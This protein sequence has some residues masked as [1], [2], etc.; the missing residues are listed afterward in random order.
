MPIEITRGPIKIVE[1][2]WGMEVWYVNNELVCEKELLVKVGGCSSYHS[3]NVKDEV[4]YIVRGICY[5]KGDEECI[6]LHPDESIRIRPGTKHMFWVPVGFH[7]NCV[8]KEV[9]THHDDADV[10][11]YEES[12]I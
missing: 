1:K 8:I 3:H 11:R 7:S 12:K 5:V 6:L 9:S 4:F 10:V 2:L